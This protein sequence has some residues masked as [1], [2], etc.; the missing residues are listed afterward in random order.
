M[1][2]PTHKETANWTDP[3]LC[4][5]P[6]LINGHRVLNGRDLGPAPP[7]DYAAMTT[8]NGTLLHSRFTQYQ[9]RR[10]TPSYEELY[11]RMS[12]LSTP[13]LRRLAH[14]IARFSE[15]SIV[16]LEQFRA[17]NAI[18]ERRRARCDA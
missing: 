16:D 9:R 7:F 5:T 14:N 18:L 10:A 2:T 17:I 4:S 8:K 3:S 12:A 1:H 13:K 11:E 6:Q 15:R